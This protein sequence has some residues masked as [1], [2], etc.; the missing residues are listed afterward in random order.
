VGIAKVSGIVQWDEK[1]A[2]TSVFDLNIYPARQG[3]LLLN[4]DGSVRS[5]TSADL[6]R[7]TVMTFRS[8]SAEVDQRGELQ[9][10]GTLTITHVERETNITW[11]NAYAGP[12]YG[13]PVA[14]STTGKVVFTIENSRSATTQGM[15]VRN[16]TLRG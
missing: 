9:V 16:R 5:Y 8:S 3:A 7:Y 13:A 14:H 6:A 10:H 2:T 12:D 1:D 15:L 4:P 11:S